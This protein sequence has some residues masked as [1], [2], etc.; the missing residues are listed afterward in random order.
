MTE[1]TVSSTG[2]IGLKERGDNRTYFNWNGLPI[3]HAESILGHFRRIGKFGE[4][5][6]RRDVFRGIVEESVIYDLFRSDNSSMVEAAFP[7]SGNLWY[8]G[9]AR[10]HESRKG[11]R[12]TEE[13]VMGVRENVRSFNSPT[14][15]I[16][17]VLDEGHTFIE[18]ISPTDPREQIQLLELWGETFGWDKEQIGNLS[19]RFLTE[20][21]NN[22]S[23]WF[24]GIKDSEGNLS[25]AAMAESIIFRGSNGEPIRI[26]ESTEWRSKEAD[27]IKAVVDHLHAQVLTDFPDAVIIAECNYHRGAHRA[28]QKSGM[29]TPDVFIYGRQVPQVLVQNVV[30]IDGN[31]PVGLR[32][33]IVFTLPNDAISPEERLEILTLTGGLK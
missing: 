33:F 29:V 3:V 31:N 25:A 20:D 15:T 30:V 1:Q 19:R 7:L 4:T 24:S 27:H 11:L 10:N 32:D 18:E 2:I 13:M 8:L 17:K 9:M 5:M 23:V 21:P 28:A 14:E 26:V 6:G 12:P 22:R 16:Q